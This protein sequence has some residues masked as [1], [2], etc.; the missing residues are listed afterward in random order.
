MVFNEKNIKLIITGKALSK[1]N[2]KRGVGRGGGFYIR[3]QYRAYEEKVRFQAKAQLIG[4]KP[5]EGDLFVRFD[6]YFQNKKHCDLLNLP[7]SVCD[8]LNKIAWIDD[9]QIKSS[10][11]ECFYDKENPRIEIFIKKIEQR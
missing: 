7:K 8:A 5:F 2:Q 1:D 9:R 10:F 6:F 4:I 11:L 3:P